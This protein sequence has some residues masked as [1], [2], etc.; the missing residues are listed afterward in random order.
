MGT[1]KTTTPTPA[2]YAPRLVPSGTPLPSRGADVRPEDRP[3]MDRLLA[4]ILG[5]KK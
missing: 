2:P 5:T 1:K 3:A 4:A